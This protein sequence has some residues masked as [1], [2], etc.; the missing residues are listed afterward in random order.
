MYSSYRTRECL[1]NLLHQK[2]FIGCSV[3]RVILRYSGAT[4]PRYQS[5][6]CAW[7]LES[8]VWEPCQYISLNSNV[9]CI[10]EKKKQIVNVSVSRFYHEDTKFHCNPFRICRHF[11]APVWYC[12]PWSHAASMPKNT[13]AF[14]MLF[15]HNIFCL[16][17][18]AYSLEH[19]PEMVK[20]GV[21]CAHFYC[22]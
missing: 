3:A 4:R 11:Q 9:F 22:E 16:P 21:K 10:I 5:N 13:A 8:V 17:T 15:L 7:K 1:S 18:A 12:Q 19:T 14:Q 20:V 6:F 2:A